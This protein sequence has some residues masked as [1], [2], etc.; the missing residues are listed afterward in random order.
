MI[1]EQH[2]SHSQGQRV[3]S[4][5]GE[6]PEKKPHFWTR[7]GSRDMQAREVAPPGGRCVLRG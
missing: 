7:T 3:E 1:R 2:N 5:W 4:D 6:L